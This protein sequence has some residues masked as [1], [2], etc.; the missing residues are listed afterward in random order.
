LSKKH[1]G[2]AHRC[3]QEAFAAGTITV[4]KEHASTNLADLFAKT[5]VAPKRED[6]LDSFTC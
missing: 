4:S 5:E 6:L 1:H 3:S 2:I